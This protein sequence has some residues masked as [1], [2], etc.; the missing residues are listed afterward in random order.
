[1]NTSKILYQTTNLVKEILEDS[2]H[3]RN[4]DTYMD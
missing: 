1:M 2:I 4:S 3:A